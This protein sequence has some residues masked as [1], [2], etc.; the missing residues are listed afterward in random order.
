MMLAAMLMG[1]MID[2]WEPQGNAF[3][4]TFPGEDA[5][6]RPIEVILDPRPSL[7][8][9]PGLWRVI[10]EMNGKLSLRAAA[11]PIETTDARDVMIRGTTGRKSTYVIGLREDGSAALRMATIL[12]DAA[13]PLKTSRE[14]QCVGF[15][16]HLD[17]WIPS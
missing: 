3:K 2:A 6:A 9:R 8:D 13:E 11:R 7:K 14:G 10:M 16:T 17:R 15:E 1:S 4:C 5:A 12:K